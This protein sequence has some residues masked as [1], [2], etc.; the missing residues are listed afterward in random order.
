MRTE[1]KNKCI[2]EQIKTG[3][4]KSERKDYREKEREKKQ[5]FDGQVQVIVKV[6][7]A[8]RIHIN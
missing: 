4:E 6:T 3:E 2:Q 7:W 8:Q 5:L 1:E